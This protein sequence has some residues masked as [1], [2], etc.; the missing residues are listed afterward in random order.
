VLTEQV[1]PP[2]GEGLDTRPSA[3]VVF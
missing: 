2:R 1:D 3:R